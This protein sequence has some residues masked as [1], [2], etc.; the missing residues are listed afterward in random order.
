M[1]GSVRGHI[2]CQVPVS[3]LGNGPPVTSA[4]SSLDHNPESPSHQSQPSLKAESRR[5]Q[6]PGPGLGVLRMW[7]AP[8][9]HVVTFPSPL[10]SSW[11]TNGAQKPLDTARP[12][13]GLWAPGS[14]TPDRGISDKAASDSVH[15]LL[16]LGFSHHLPDKPETRETEPHGPLPLSHTEITQQGHTTEKT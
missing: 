12:S 6:S 13:S 1:A 5:N 7:A 8:D 16:Q 9:K 3:H 15:L 11:D 2:T 14:P 10:P 4:L